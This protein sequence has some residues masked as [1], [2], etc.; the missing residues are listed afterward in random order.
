MR[1]RAQHELTA[2][3]K[4]RNLPHDAIVLGLVFGFSLRG[5]LGDLGCVEWG[6]DPHH[7]V[8]CEEFTSVVRFDCDAV[9]DFCGPD[10]TY[11]GVHL[12]GEVHVLRRAVAH[13]FKLPVGGHEGDG[14]VGVELPELDAL[15][16][17]AVFQGHRSGSG[18][19]SLLLPILI[20]DS[21]GVSGPRLREQE[22]VVEAELAFGGPTEV[23]A[24]DDLAVDVG[25]EDGAGCGHEEVDVFDYVDESFV[26]AVLDVASSPG[27]R[28]RRLHGDLRSVA[29]GACRGAD[30][31]G[32]VVGR[33]IHLQDIHICVLGVAEVQDFWL[34]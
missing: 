18:A 22:L 13:Q 15:V 29:G 24:H 28:A 7:D 30:G 11:D 32:E 17:L 33:Y 8:R 3:D 23:G 1:L 27:L 6:G 19:G 14:A 9:F 34:T 16:E 12:E 4:S 10:F 25:A 2:P 31:G 20:A 21:V 26:F 5:P